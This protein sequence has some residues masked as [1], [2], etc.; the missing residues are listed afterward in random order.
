MSNFYVTKPSRKDPTTLRI[1]REFPTF[2]EALRWGERYI[3]V[4]DKRFFI[5]NENGH[6]MATIDFDYHQPVV[7]ISK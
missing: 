2:E 6:R 7:K 1:I 3:Y 5:D 4:D